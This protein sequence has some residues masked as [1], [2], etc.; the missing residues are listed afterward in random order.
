MT[1]AVAM[2]KGGVGKTTSTVH[3]SRGAALAELRTLVVDLDPQANVTSALAKDVPARTDVSIAD[4]L[5]P[6]DDCT[7]DDVLIP[8]LWPGVDL[9]P[10]TGATLAAGE[11]RVAA[12]TLGREARLRTILDPIRSLYDLVLIDCPP[13]L[14][15]LTVN[16][17]VAAHKVLVVAEAEQFSLDGL[18]MLR[19][20]VHGVQSSYNPHLTWAGVL[21][22]K[23][24]DTTTNK[25]VL[26]ELVEHFTEAEPWTYKVPHWTGIG[27]AVAAGVGLDSWDKGA[28]R[29]RILAE[30]YR[31]WTLELAEANQ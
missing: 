14:G 24:R 17:L 29:F 9:A 31:H 5:D 8:A 12:M 7:L 4:A 21:V 10:S 13:A 1:V 11:Q 23:W 19:D 25:D 6:N 20:T 27:D 18:D 22:N 30:Q 2:Q 28:A 15:Q 3:L 16:A 26:A